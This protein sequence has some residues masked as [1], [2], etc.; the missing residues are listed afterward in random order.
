[1]NSFTKSEIEYI[2]SITKQSHYLEKIDLYKNG[3]PIES[4]SI[5]ND[6]PIGRINTVFNE[7]SY[8]SMSLQVIILFTTLDM[9][10]FR[11][12]KEDAKDKN[13]SFQDRFILLPEGND[14]EKIYK[15]C[16]GIM[17]FARNKCVHE[18][19][20]NDGYYI[21]LNIYSLTEKGW[22]YLFG[23]VNKLIE[24]YRVDRISKRGSLNKYDAE[25]LKLYIN[26]IFHN[27]SFKASECKNINNIIEAI[28]TLKTGMNIDLSIHPQRRRHILFFKDIGE[29]KNIVFDDRNYPF[30]D[31][32]GKKYYYPIAK[33]DEYLITLPDGK[34]YL[35][36][37]HQF[38]DNIEDW[39]IHGN[40]I[41][42]F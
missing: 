12:E 8:K 39:A 5:S 19:I 28:K 36:I 7:P 3:K 9:L 17:R 38:N 22:L 37:G 16:Y 34:E 14:A 26:E 29:Y 2:S 32:Y 11:T 4:L 1:M 25:I 27:I 6:I 41:K 15:I 24:L 30:A 40:Y 18:S 13:K 21:N 20:E 31:I 10:Y 35:F 33:M 42:N 23:L